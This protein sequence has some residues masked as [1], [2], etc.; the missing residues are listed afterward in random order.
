MDNLYQN[1]LCINGSMDQWINS[2]TTGTIDLDQIHTT[3]LIPFL[4]FI[5]QYPTKTVSIS[6]LEGMIA[7]YFNKT[8][9][10]QII[11]WYND[12]FVKNIIMRYGLKMMYLEM[13]NHQLIVN[14]ISTD[15]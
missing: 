15:H 13:H 14:K 8:M 7:S 9:N 3:D 10:D 4:K 5:D 12:P 6:L 11:L 2:C 1:M